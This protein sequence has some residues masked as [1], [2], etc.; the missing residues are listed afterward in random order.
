[1]IDANPNYNS[2]ADIPFAYIPRDHRYRQNTTDDE[3]EAVF[4]SVQLQPNDR[5]DVTVDF[6]YSERDQR[7]MRK[8]LQFGT[9]QEYLSALTSNPATGV[10]FSSISETQINS[11]TTD[12]Q[13]LEE[14]EGYGINFDYALTD[15]LSLSLDYATSETVRTETDVELR[16]AAS[17]NNTCRR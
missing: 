2:V 13:R 9:T 8:D 12:F 16:L 4:G 14:Y 17:D 1:M 7:E 5:L 10:V 3:R 11:Y 15:N 6:Q